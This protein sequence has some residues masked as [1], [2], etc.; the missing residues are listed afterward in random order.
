MQAYFIFLQ[1][2]T[3]GYFTRIG[4]FY[5]VNSCKRSWFTGVALVWSH[6]QG[7]VEFLLLALGLVGDLAQHLADDVREGL[8][9][10]HV[11]HGHALLLEVVALAQPQHGHQ[12]QLAVCLHHRVLLLSAVH[13]RRQQ[14]PQQL[15]LRFLR[16]HD[17]CQVD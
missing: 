8:A 1:R 13:Q 7:V 3:S 16:G 10:A 14:R 15:R 9:R 11:Q 2:D 5:S 12:C 4:K 17:T 6:E